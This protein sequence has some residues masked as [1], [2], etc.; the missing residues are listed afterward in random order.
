MIDQ[1]G[2]LVSVFA[3]AGVKSGAVGQFV[4]QQ[5]GDRR[6][7]GQLTLDRGKAWQSLRAKWDT[8]DIAEK[9]QILEI[10]CL[11]FRLEGATLMP[12]IRKPFDVLAEGP[13]VRQTRGDW[14]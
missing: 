1:R 9:W 13:F 8:A 6:G 7:L 3:C 14:I 4:E 10:V 5:P 12:T 2:Y 11:N